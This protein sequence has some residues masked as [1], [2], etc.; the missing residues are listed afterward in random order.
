MKRLIYSSLLIIVVVL[1]ACDNGKPFVHSGPK[2]I[3][4]M[5]FYNNGNGVGYTLAY[6]EQ[7]DTF[8][9]VFTDSLHGKK[10]WTRYNAYSI[11]LTDTIKDAQGIIIKNKD[12]K[13]SL[14][15]KTVYPDKNLILFDVGIDLDSFNNKHL[16]TI[17]SQ[18]LK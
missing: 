17:P 1:M 18:P 5:V 4:T 6:R 3:K 14:G 12:G 13:D 11:P 2:K 8:D 16:P 10:Q 15:I 9:L 7:R